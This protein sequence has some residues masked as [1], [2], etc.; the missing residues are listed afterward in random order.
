MNSTRDEMVL[1]VQ[2][3][4]N[5]TYGDQFEAA[6]YSRVE[7]N[8]ITSWEITNAL[9]MGLQIEL[10][11][12]EI[13]PSF[14]PTTIGYMDA[15]GPISEGSNDSNKN[16]NQIIKGGCFCT[17][18]PPGVFNGDF[19]YALTEG[20]M[21][22]QNDIG[23]D[24]TGIVDTKL[25]KALLS[26]NAYVVLPGGSENV[27]IFQ[28][29]LN[30][31]YKRK[32]NFY[33]IP[34]DGLYS[35]NTQ[36]GIV[37]GIQFECDLDNIANGWFGPSTQENLKEKGLVYLNDVDTSK[38]FVHLFKGA[39]LCNKPDALI[40]FN[41][42]YD[43][44]LSINVKEFQQFTALEQT[45]NGDFQTWA[46]L[47]V[48]TG[49][50]SRKTTAL[51]CSINKVTG[52]RAKLFKEQGYKYI[53]RYLTNDGPSGD[54]FD[55]KL[56]QYEIDAIFAEGMS[57]FPIYQTY[58]HLE[59]HF[60]YN[61]GYTDGNKAFNLA[62][63]K[64]GIPE[65]TTIY[66]PVDF[67][68]YEYQVED[69]ITKYFLGVNKSFNETNYY[70]VGIYGARNTCSIISEKELASYSFVSGMSIGFSG[71]LGFPLPDNWSFNQIFEDENLGIDND[72]A[73]DRDKGFNHQEEILGDHWNLTGYR[74]T[75]TGGA[76]LGETYLGYDSPYGN[77]NR[78]F[79]N[80]DDKYFGYE[81]KAKRNGNISTWF[82]V[83]DSATNYFFIPKEDAEFEV[84][85]DPYHNGD[86]LENHPFMGSGL[87]K[88]GKNIAVTGK[89][90]VVE[91]KDPET[92]EVIAVEQPDTYDSA[93]N[94]NKRRFT[95]NFA[96]SE[97]LYPCAK[98]YGVENKVM[99][100]DNNKYLF[101][102]H[103]VV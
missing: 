83:I 81:V 85:K 96:D 30:G 84:K 94:E 9:I 28:K 2:K 48:S 79:Y 56:E 13:A 5:E 87:L 73:S 72:V 95:V 70:K 54:D 34:C 71:N 20:I 53:G 80:T 39:F 103:I 29:W 41:G 82:V 67:D 36:E 33:Y 4:V 59:D 42:F 64:Y 55:K 93:L 44:V 21:I 89:S 66:F 97:K 100:V 35:R 61:N 65:G 16:I 78:E 25:M 6:G 27:R 18:Y 60:D 69:I 38:N 98:F 3:W 68:A 8:G 63:E 46:E 22:L 91:I 88:Q 10:G 17:G 26:M 86:L 31:T 74:Y 90:L 57:I 23:I 52:A 51:D 11:I 58:H 45:G 76:F 32:E 24:N 14:G 40:V 19:D 62:R 92:G 77:Q 7:E 12:S 47:L 102:V 1:E 101:V 50:E 75:I 15:H 37:Y 49:D 43:E 99:I